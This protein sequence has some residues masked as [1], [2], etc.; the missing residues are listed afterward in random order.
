MT[1]GISGT[2]L[3]DH[4]NNTEDSKERLVDGCLHENSF[5]VGKSVSDSTEWKVIGFQCGQE[6]FR[7]G[8]TPADVTILLLR[9]E[10][11]SALDSLKGVQI[12]MSKLVDEKEEVK[13]SEKQSRE[14][15]KCLTGQVLRLK[16]EMNDM[17]K[18][19][20]FR[21]TELNHKLKMMGEMVKEADSYISEAQE[22]KPSSELPV[23]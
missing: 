16:T 6:E 8:K 9:K 2:E 17:E 11:E 21:I 7:N 14:S 3:H 18:Q 12:Q 4:Q 22:V 1:Q 19:I 20:D 23:M 5:K 13:K 15:I 10:L